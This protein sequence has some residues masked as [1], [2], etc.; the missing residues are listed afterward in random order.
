[1]LSTLSISSSQARLPGPNK[2][3]IDMT[4]GVIAGIFGLEMHYQQ[5][6]VEQSASLLMKYWVRLKCLEL[7]E[8]GLILQC[9]GISSRKLKAQKP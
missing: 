7:L 2:P 3:C 5:A 9:I 4:A 8:T 1:M 6:A